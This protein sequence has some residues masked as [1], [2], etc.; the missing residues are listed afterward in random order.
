VQIVRQLAE[1]GFAFIFHVRDV[2]SKSSYALKRIFASGREEVDVLKYEVKLAKTLEPHPNIVH[3]VDADL[4]SNGGRVEAYILMELCEGPT[5]LDRMNEFAMAGR[6]LPEGLIMEIFASVVEAVAHLHRQ[7]PPIWH[8]DVKVENVLQD[9]V[10]TWK[11]CDFGS[12]T[13]KSILCRGGADVAR[14]EDELNRYSTPTYRA[15]EMCDLYQG[16]RVGVQADVWALGCLLFRMCFLANAFDENKL[17]ILNGTV[18]IPSNSPYSPALHGLITGLL[19]KDPDERP[20]IV[21]VSATV[22]I[23]RAPGPANP[24]VTVGNP[25]AAGRKSPA[26]RGGARSPAAGAK[27]SEGESSWEPQWGS[28]KQAEVRTP[29]AGGRLNPESA[30]FQGR[31]KRRHAAGASKASAPASGANAAQFGLFEG[32]TT[33]TAPSAEAKSGEQKFFDDDFFSCPFD[34]S[35]TDSNSQSSRTPP[36]VSGGSSAFGQTTAPGGNPI[37]GPTNGSGAEANA[38]VFFSPTPVSGGSSGGLSPGMDGRGLSAQEL[39]KQRCSPG[40]AMAS[41][42][43]R[44]PGGLGPAYATPLGPMAMHQPQPQRAAVGLMG[45]RLLSEPNFAAPYSAAPQ[46]Q[47]GLHPSGYPL[48]TVTPPNTPM[49][50]NDRFSPGLHLSMDAQGPHRHQYQHHTRSQSA[51]IPG[52]EMDAIQRIRSFQASTPQHVTPTASTPVVTSVHSSP[53]SATET[54]P[55]RDPFADLL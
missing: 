2:N 34:A 13:T 54:T 4:H 50:P 21:H 20:D 31:S 47:V 17:S 45:Q 37:A 55:K 29:Q 53:H 18:R 7:D 14:Y 36:A 22:G 28:V 32:V 26:M 51:S 40:A 3:F 46:Q 12:A 25:F 6:K 8:R 43:G 30:K 24:D 38:P 52:Q 15:P 42:G 11:L 48:P 35:A 39:L 27:T 10:G 1:G 16:K 23:M 9:N 44:H 33:E 49:R 41:P 19:V 5:L